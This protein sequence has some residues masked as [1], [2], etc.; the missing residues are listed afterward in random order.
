MLLV[1]SCSYTPKG[2]SSQLGV[3]GRKKGPERSD[4]LIAAATATAAAAAT[5]ALNL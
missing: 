4:C 2:L 5:T 3:K 1:C